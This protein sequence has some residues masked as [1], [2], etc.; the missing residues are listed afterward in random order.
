MGEKYAARIE[1]LS[2]SVYSAAA[3][4]AR[5]RGIIVADTKL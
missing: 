1:E 2:L 4:Y 3:A 5:E